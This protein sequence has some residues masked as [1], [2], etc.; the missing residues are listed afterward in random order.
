MNKNSPFFAGHA[1]ALLVA[2]AM[3]VA[4]AVLFLLDGLGIISKHGGPFAP[5]FYMAPLLVLI[6][7]LIAQMERRPAIRVIG[8]FLV[9]AMFVAIYANA[10]L[11]DH[12]QKAAIT[13]HAPADLDIEQLVAKQRAAASKPITVGAADLPR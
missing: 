3:V 11:T 13:V 12:E 2:A 8:S 9:T 5:A 7:S 1:G 4:L 10:M 6:V